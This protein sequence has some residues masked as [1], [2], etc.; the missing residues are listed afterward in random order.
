MRKPGVIAFASPSSETAPADHSEAPAPL[1]RLGNQ[2]LAD[3]DRSNS[4]AAAFVRRRGDAPAGCGAPG[5]QR[6][7]DPPIII[8]RESFADSVAEQLTTV[9]IEP[10]KI[11]LEPVARS[12]AAAIGAGALSELIEDCDPILLAMPT[13]HIIAD[14]G[15]FTEAVRT[16]LPA[17]EAGGIVTFGV[18]ATRPETRYGYLEIARPARK[19]AVTEVA[20]FTEKPDAATAATFVRSGVHFWNTG[21]FLFRATTLVDEL[22]HYAPEI[23]LGCEGA[24]ACATARGKFIRLERERFSSCPSIAI[25]YAVMEKSK[26]I[27]MVEADMG[28]SDLG[29]WEAQW[30]IGVKDPNGNVVLGN[31]LLLDSRGCLVR[32]ELDVPLA[33]ADATDLIVVVSPSG[34][35]VMP[36]ASAQK[37]RFVADGIAARKQ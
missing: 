15:A 14:V 29:S 5:S 11:L 16:G 9:G 25:D 10:H 30:E 21:I 8:T 18:P 4:Q 19:A 7:F 31:V 1:R 34:P 37:T 22:R 17:A 27:Y 20:R 23:A 2:A 3:L 33:V 24:V 28:W 13:D 6:L 26:R 35:L 12:T 36:R 32:N